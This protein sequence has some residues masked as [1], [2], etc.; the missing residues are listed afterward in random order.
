MDYY[1]IHGRGTLAEQFVR[2]KDFSAAGLR[3][4]DAGLSRLIRTDPTLRVVPVT[5][6]PVLLPDYEEFPSASTLILGDGT[7]LPGFREKRLY[8]VLFAR[9]PADPRAFG[10][11]EEEG[12]S[13]RW[14]LRS[15]GNGVAWCLDVAAHLNEGTTLGPVL[16]RLTDQ[17]R[18]RQGLIPV[19]TERFQ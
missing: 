19:T 12:D 17:M 10:E 6:E 5:G 3:S 4:S 15:I 1:L 13:Y 2:R 8:R 11:L 9:S 14:Q 16:D 7:P 18:H